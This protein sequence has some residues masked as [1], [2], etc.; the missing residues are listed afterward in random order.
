[1]V[2]Q[3]TDKRGPS[4]TIQI[5]D[6]SFASNFPFFSTFSIKEDQSKNDIYEKSTAN[7]AKTPGLIEN[8]S[9]GFEN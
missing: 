2:S 9:Q 5:T 8:S 4:Q 7:R 3:Y 6:N 1:M